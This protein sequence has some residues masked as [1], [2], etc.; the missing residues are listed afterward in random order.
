MKSV[1]ILCAGLQASCAT[2]PDVVPHIT[3]VCVV[4]TDG[5]LCNGERGAHSQTFGASENW[6]CV[7]PKDWESLIG[8]LKRDYP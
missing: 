6:L 7:D 3:D 4:G 2:P 1:A 8:R 5:M